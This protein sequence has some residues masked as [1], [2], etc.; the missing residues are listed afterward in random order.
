MIAFTAVLVIL[1]TGP[2]GL[3]K[4][5]LTLKSTEIVAGMTEPV[6]VDKPVMQMF[7]PQCEEIENLQIYVCSENINTILQLRVKDAA[8]QDLRVVQTDISNRQEAGFVSFRIDLPVQIGQEY[9]YTVESLGEEAL[10]GL[11]E[12]FFRGLR[13]TALIITTARKCRMSI[14]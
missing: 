9:Y 3:V 1:I 5:H 11:E 2:L 14:S 13:Q 10:L 8:F 6:S 4:H 7:V 12:D